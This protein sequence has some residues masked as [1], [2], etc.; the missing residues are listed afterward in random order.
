MLMETAQTNNG[1]LRKSL[2]EQI[3]RLDAILTGLAD[4]LN[5]SVAAAVTAAV[6]QAVREAVQAVLT[7]VLTNP[8][9]LQ[10][11]HGAAAGAAVPAAA[12]PGLGA[13]LRRAGGRVAEGARAAR[14]GCASLW[15]RAWQGLGA[16]GPGLA[17]VHRHRRRVLAATGV[18]VAAG[19]VAYLAGPLLSAA[20][21]ALAGFTAALAVRAGR[22]LYGALGALGLGRLA[23]PAAE[24]A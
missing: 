7:D 21:S 2:A 23:G 15:G 6:A 14:D 20:L 22:W 12:G 8:E 17:L 24:A 10:L 9:L 5:K 11:L 19:V 16:L 1:K 3:D 13:C 4:A 18:G